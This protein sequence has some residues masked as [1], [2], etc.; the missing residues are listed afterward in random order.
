MINVSVY[1][2]H[3]AFL[4]S[5]AWYLKYVQHMQYVIDYRPVHAN[6]PSTIE[7]LVQGPET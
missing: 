4:H 6:S 7:E 5:C 3:V 1:S 2:M